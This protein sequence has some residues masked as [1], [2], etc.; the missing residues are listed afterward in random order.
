WQHFLLGSLPLPLAS[1]IVLLACKMSCTHSLIPV[2]LKRS[3]KDPLPERLRRITAQL[4]RSQDLRS[5]RV[6]RITEARELE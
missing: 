1:P 5:F 6:F 4:V 3:N 2:G